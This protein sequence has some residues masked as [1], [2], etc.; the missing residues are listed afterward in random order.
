MLALIKLTT[1]PSNSNGRERSSEIRLA[2]TSGKTPSGFL[3]IMVN[4]SPPSLA[5]ISAV[6]VVF[7]NISA[8]FTKASLTSQE[9]RTLRGIIKMLSGRRMCKL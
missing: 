2:T 3:R 4:S 7:L 5:A 9:V 1:T 8:I 6:L